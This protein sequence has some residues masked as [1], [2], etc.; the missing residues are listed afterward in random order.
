MFNKYR[1]F[2]SDKISIA[3][4]ILLYISIIVE[5][6]STLIERNNI[7]RE[8]KNLLLSLEL[9]NPG[10]Y[11]LTF[12]ALFNFVHEMNKIRM[13]IMKIDSPNNNKLL[14]F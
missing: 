10:I 4:L 8:N 9:L 11:G 2:D 5:I 13:R 3:T 7:L 14:L 12:I 6:I 1:K